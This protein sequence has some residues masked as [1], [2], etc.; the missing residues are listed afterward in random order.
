MFV[1]NKP[2][3]ERFT[4]V[5]RQAFQFAARYI[6]VEIQIDNIS[7]QYQISDIRLEPEV[8]FDMAIDDN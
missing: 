1:V 3:T 4:L 2:N 7:N 6:A 8:V 5:L